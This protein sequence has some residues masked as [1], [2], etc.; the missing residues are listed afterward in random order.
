MLVTIGIVAAA[1]LLQLCFG[2]EYDPP[3]TYIPRPK[4]YD[5][6]FKVLQQEFEQKLDGVTRTYYVAIEEL[7][8]NYTATSDDISE[9]N[10]A[11]F[12]TNKSKR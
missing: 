11:Y 5:G 2:I 6:D 10:P 4:N 3:E 9:D 12:W 8:W 7:V 1:L